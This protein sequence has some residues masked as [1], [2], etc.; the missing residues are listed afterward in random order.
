M[1][2]RVHGEQGAWRAGCMESRVHGEQGAW[3]AGCMESRVHGE[4]GDMESRAKTRKDNR[5][6]LEH[7]RLVDQ[8]LY[9]PGLDWNTARCW[10]VQTREDDSST[11]V[12]CLCR[13]SNDYS[14]YPPLGGSIKGTM[15]VKSGVNEMSGGAM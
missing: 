8:Q 5:G 11:G 9:Q 7:L 4:Q 12:G 15:D 3:R 14:V 10:G 13:T 2:S 6:S 1:E